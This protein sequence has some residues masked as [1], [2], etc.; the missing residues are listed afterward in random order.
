MTDHSSKVRAQESHQKLPID[1]F[2]RLMRS[3]D[4]LKAEKNL[5][6]KS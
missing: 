5:Q 6:K 3:Y 4:L 1:A 2:R